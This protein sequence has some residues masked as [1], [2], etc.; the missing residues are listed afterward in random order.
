MSIQPE[1]YMNP[2]KIS[3]K[4]NLI[5]S[6]KISLSNFYVQI[7]VQFEIRDKPSINPQAIGRLISTDTEIS[8]PSYKSKNPRR[9][10]SP[11]RG[12]SNNMFVFS[13]F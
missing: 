9:D 7:T 3:V 12:G 6:L 8:G 2:C 11:G 1:A 4:S 13:Q 10:I 5:K